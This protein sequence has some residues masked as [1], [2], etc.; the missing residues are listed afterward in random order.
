MSD[1]VEDYLIEKAVDIWCERLHRPIFDNGDPSETGFLGMGL[2]S[3]NCEA[4]KGGLDMAEAVQKFRGNLI[5]N[6]KAKRDEE[7]YFYA[8]LSVDYG[9]SQ[10]LAEAAEGTGITDSMFSIKST[11]QI[12]EDHVSASFGY[13]APA[14]NFYKYDGKW[15]LLKSRLAESERDAILKAISQGLINGFEIE[16]AA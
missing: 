3:M 11:V 10:E 5:S 2:A 13:G 1:K 14:T 7:E 12:S 6:L 16:E 4:S 8:Y 15:I 9:P